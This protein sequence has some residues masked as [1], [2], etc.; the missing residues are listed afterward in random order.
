MSRAAFLA[1]AAL[2]VGCGGDPF[3]FAPPLVDGA[4][5]P[6]DGP[7]LVDAA[8]P[9]DARRDVEDLAD[10]GPQPPAVDG[11][12]LDAGAPLDSAPDRAPADAGADVLEAGPASA[13]CCQGSAGVACAG[14]AGFVCYPPGSSCSASCQAS[15]DGGQTCTASCT[16]NAAACSPSACTLGA[17]CLYSAQG[18][19]WPG[20]I[21]R[22]N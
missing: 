6:I 18:Q 16:G 12:W 11:G 19:T 7:P 4:P 8:P 10:A 17:Q 3:T 22:C 13:V 21:E 9:A 20:T 14:G 2:L 5:A 15:A 1:G